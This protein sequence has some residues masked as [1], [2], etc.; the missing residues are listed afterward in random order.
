M[1]PKESMSNENRAHYEEMMK[2]GQKVI[3][4]MNTPLGRERMIDDWR[5]KNKGN[6]KEISDAEISL[7]IEKDAGSNI[8]KAIT[9]LELD[10][11]VEEIYNKARLGDFSV[12]LPPVESPKPQQQAEP[13]VHTAEAGKEADE[14]SALESVGPLFEQAEKEADEL[15]EPE[16]NAPDVD[17]PN[18]PRINGAGR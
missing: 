8:Q 2:E 6:K 9:A 11:T 18:N 5:I 1:M 3:Y 10:V 12:P 13:N 16:P 15:E 4:R 7:K 17:R 14:D